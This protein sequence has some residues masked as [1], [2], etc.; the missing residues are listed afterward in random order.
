MITPAPS[1]RVNCP[2]LGWSLSGIRQGRLPD[3]VRAGSERD[4][5]RVRRVEALVALA[6]Q[7]HSLFEEPKR[8]VQRQISALEAG[9]PRLELVERLLE[10][11][12]LAHAGSVERARSIWLMV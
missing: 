6:Y 3:P 11:T 9:H 5:A 2:L 4:D 8:L 12:G 7:R 10:G 1:S